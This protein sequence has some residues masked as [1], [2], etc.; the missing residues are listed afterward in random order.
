M[1]N[2]WHQIWNNKGLDKPN[3]SRDEFDVFCDLKRA[4]GYD[5]NV[6]NEKEY[7]RNFYQ[8]WMEMYNRLMEIAKDNIH[9]VYEVGCGS[10]VNLYL[11]KNRI[12]DVVVGGIDYSEGLVKMAR[13]VTGCIDIEC[14]SA[15]N[16]DMEVKFDLVMAGAVFQYFDSLEYA[17]TV[18]IKM[19]QKSDKIIYISELHDAELQEK[20]IAYRRASME[21]YDKI[22]EGLGKMFYDRKWISDI[23]GRFGKKVIFTERNNPEYWNSKYEFNCFIF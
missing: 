19:L 5:V 8:E 23:A 3:L 10:G 11:F 15:D 20:W 14:G 13:S 4:N 21:D 2:K 12:P 1:N 18:L 22:Y 6:H 16:M 17:E 7:F 9:S